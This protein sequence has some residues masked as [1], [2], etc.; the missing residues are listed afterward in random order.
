MAVAALVALVAALPG[1]G[2]RSTFGGNAAVDEPQYLLTALSL[3]EDRDADIADELA[4]R[5]WA[6]FH[7]AALPVQ[8]EVLDG[9]RQVS[10]HD[11]LLALLL[12]VPMGLGGWVAAKAAL[13][14]LAAAL[15]AL[16]V[17]VAVR[18][19]GVGLGLATVGV[20]LAAASP[21]LAVYATQVYPELPAALVLLAGVAAATGSL[22]RGGVVGVGLAVVALPWLSVKYAPVAAVLAVVAL[23]RLLRAGRRRAAGWLAGCLAIAAVAY[24]L[25]HQAVWGGWT[26][27]ASGDHFVSTGELSV[28]GVAPDYFGR[29]LRL[30]GLLVDS[31]FGIAAWAPAWLLA[32]PALAAALRRRPSWLAPVALPLLAGWLVATFV[33]LTMHG[34]W[35]PGRQV[36]VVLPLAL[37]LVLAFVGRAGRRLRAAAGAFAGLGVLAYGWLVVDGWAGRLTW[38]T[39]FEHVGNP[40]YTLWRLLLPDYRGGGAGLWLRHVVWVAVLIALAAWGWRHAPRPADRA[41]EPLLTSRLSTR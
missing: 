16:S 6:A 7:D 35:W 18:R 15:A 26:V 30:A 5:R 14:L 38:V 9:G 21:P 41:P 20:S 27:Y 1:I 24:L 10:P 12:A 31:G 34:F 4:E 23:T 8:T 29:S 25:V 17:W 40:A 37:L 32:V 39:G 33:A 28:A 19:L 2:V 22:R 36:V 3:Y 13:A 11:P